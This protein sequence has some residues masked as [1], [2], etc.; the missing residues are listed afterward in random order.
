MEK[1]KNIKIGDTVYIEK[2]IRYSFN[3]SNSFFIPNKVVHVTATQFKTENGNR[4]KKDGRK[5]GESSQCYNLGD[6]CGWNNKKVVCDQSNEMIEF[7]KIVRMVESNDTRFRNLGGKRNFKM[8]LTD[9]LKISE[10][11]GKIEKLLSH[12]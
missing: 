2:T 7:V 8:S 6:T 10:L 4:Y 3:N 12:E 1:F 5:I 9:V 11:I